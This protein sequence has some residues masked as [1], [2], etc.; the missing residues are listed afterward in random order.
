LEESKSSITDFEQ[1]YGISFSEFEEKWHKG[2]ILEKNSYQ[3]EQDLLAWEAAV[4]DK[5]ALEELIDQLA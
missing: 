2:E 4:T 3:V 5:K 1:K